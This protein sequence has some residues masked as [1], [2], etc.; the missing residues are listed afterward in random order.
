MLLRYHGGDVE[1]H[2]L[3]S[4]AGL[5]EIARNAETVV[6]AAHLLK[7]ALVGV[8]DEA[9]GGAL[10]GEVHRRGLDLGDGP[11]RCDAVRADEGR[12]PEPPPIG[13]GEAG[14][15]DLGHVGIGGA[16]A[17]EAD[18]GLGR[19]GGLIGYIGGQAGGAAKE[20]L[21]L[22][23]GDRCFG[24]I[25]ALIRVAGPGAAVLAIGHHRVVA[26]VGVAAAGHYPLVRKNYHMYQGF[27]VFRSRYRGSA[28]AGGWGATARQRGSP[29]CRWRH[30]PHWP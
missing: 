26:A 17:K 22:R 20:R 10:G 18:E 11:A 1:A 2:L 19:N 28:R 7:E 21:H 23:D 5:D 16:V 13:V 4:F 27:F 29:R 15:E 30:R 14:V 24:G 6:E 25:G 9:G 3:A 8:L 12:K